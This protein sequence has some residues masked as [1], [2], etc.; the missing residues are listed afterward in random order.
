MKDRS[1]LQDESPVDELDEQLVAYL[2]GE[3]SYEDVRTLEDRLS[4]D[5]SLRD[6]L[7]E[8]Q[9]G[10][11]MLDALPLAASS[12]QLLETTIRMAAVEGNPHSANGTTSRWRKFPFYGWVIA[13]TLMSLLLGIAA[14]RV[15]SYWKFRRQLQ[16][17]PVAMNLDAYLNAPDLELM[18]MLQ[19]MPEWQHAVEVAERLGVWDFSLSQQVQEASPSQLKSLLPN[20]PVDAQNV[21]ASAWDRFESVDIQTRQQVVTTARTVADQPDADELLGTMNRYAAWL[22]AMP[23]EM[24]D[25][26]ASGSVESRQNAIRKALAASTYAWTEERGRL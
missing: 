2:D 21:V 4:A 16:D 12:P 5:P 10:W 15:Q 20:L 26:I 9:N 24:R 17:L 7:R 1:P 25:R 22:A 18:R 8:L 13:A 11:E 6:R 23:A 14:S 3:L 19:T